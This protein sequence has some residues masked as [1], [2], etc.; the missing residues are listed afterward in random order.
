MSAAVLAAV[1]GQHVA[2]VVL[3]VVVGLTIASFTCVII[4]RMPVPFDEPNEFGELYGTRP[5][6]EVVGG[7][8]R[9]SSCGTPVRPIENIPV[10]GWLALRGKCRTCGE[11]I[12]GFHPV[13]EA[14]IPL[15]GLLAYWQLGWVWLLLPLFWLI[16][17]GVAVTVI[18]LRTMIVPTRLIWPAFFVSVPL[19]VIAAIGAD[20]PRALVSACIGLATL[21][22][23]L[24]AIWFVMPS[25]IG[26]GDV[27]LT[28][29]LGFNVGLA[30]GFVDSASIVGPVIL[31]LITLTL[32]SLLGIVVGVALRVGFGRPMP[33]GPTLVAAALFSMI[34]AP[35]ILD[36][37]LN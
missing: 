9:C 18:D 4:D 6:R 34:L 16:P 7:H 15:I 33:F 32:G 1:D 36:P 19:C 37:F 20:E 10:F 35:Q 14:L 27:R 8:S 13:V 23:P 22:G 17:T 24:M 11:R 29:L 26:F 31:C 5:W 3:A 25:G 28:T 30:A 21:A 2:Y 12:P